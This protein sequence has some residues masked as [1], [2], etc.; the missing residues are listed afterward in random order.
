MHRGKILLFASL[1]ISCSQE[2]RIGEKN[3]QNPATQADSAYIIDTSVP[4]P[5]D[6]A[7]T[8][9]VEEDLYPMIEITPY[10]YDFGDVHLNCSEEYELTISSTGTSPLVIDELI[11]INTP[12]LSMSYDFKLPV[13]LEPGEQVV[14]RFDYDENDL[15]EDI[16]R[17]YIYS[18]ARGKSEQ[19]VSHYGQGVIAGSQIDVFEHEQVN[20]ADILFVVDN[21]CSMSQ[22]QVD[23]SDN[24]EEFVDK[25]IGN[26]TDFQ[27]SVITTD[28]SD[29]VSTFITEDTV[30]AGKALADAVKV[31]TDG[32]AFEMGQ[33]MAKNSL[34]LGG[35]LGKGFVRDDATLSI[36]VVSDEDDYSP[37][38]EFEYYDF[39]ISI[40]D[41]ELFFFHSVVGT[42]LYPGCTIEIG[43][44][45]L[46]QSL[47]TG[48]IS[49]DV[50][51]S[52]GSSLTTLASQVFIVE[53][54][55]PLTKQAIP[56]SVEVY[57]GGFLLSEGWYYDEAT[58]SVHI[59][60]KEGII[61]QELL[62]IMYDY[63]S[64]CAE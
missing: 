55:Y 5:K 45:Y 23:L 12:D 2:Y 6:T 63:E 44:R 15:F 43:D 33:E 36:V 20:K 13:V 7:D 34:E 27:I 56:S 4:I 11:Y 59:T 37:L 31:G 40:K 49:L 53:T 35:P 57:T 60:E 54:I 51:S 42:A 50:C 21:S 30:E 26:G 17:L 22:E 46:D 14:V 25:L 8:G 18:N 28:S 16:G 29:P 58:N 52:W 41:E 32:Y 24:A 3:K 64:D 47:Y 39:F 9:G 19:K 61:E 10:D 38:T 1:L 48:G 62:F